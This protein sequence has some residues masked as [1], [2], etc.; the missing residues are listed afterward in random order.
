MKI[1]LQ[2]LFDKR[3]NG[4]SI[5]GSSYGQMIR[6]MWYHQKGKS[7]FL[8]SDLVRLIQECLLCRLH[9]LR[10]PLLCCTEHHVALEMTF[11]FQPNSDRKSYTRR[12]NLTF[13]RCLGV[14]DLTLASMKMSNSSGFTWGLKLISALNCPKHKCA[15]FPFV[16]HC[17]Y[18]LCTIGDSIQP[19]AARLFLN[20]PSIYLLR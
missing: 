16:I 13:D 19:L 2:V 14:M 9:F 5:N 10:L 15:H 6:A 1:K 4:I 3:S 18:F 17:H 7:S 11:D 8:Q 12:G 20:N